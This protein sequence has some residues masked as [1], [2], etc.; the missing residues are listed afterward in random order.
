[1]DMAAMTAIRVKEKTISLEQ[2]L[3]LARIGDSM[4]VVAEA[5]EALV[6]RCWAEELGVEAGVEELQADLTQFR[7]TNGL[8]TAAQTKEW[9]DSRGVTVEELTDFLEPSILYRKLA[10][11]IVTKE[12]I[13]RYFLENALRYDQAVISRIVMPEYGQVQELRFRLEEGADFHRLARQYSH[14]EETRRAGGYAGAI[15]RH[16][17]GPEQSA[18]VFSAG[19]GEIVGPF[20]TR[21]GFELILVEELY[22]AELT[23]TLAAELRELL[24]RERLEAYADALDISK[25]IW[26]P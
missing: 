16:D 1:M 5:E 22:P 20:E 14:D 21:E 2:L 13:E 25:D 9:L 17:V 15:G 11:S 4:P 3:R 24:F 7:K 26:E 18:A 8:Y 6:L 19:E 12:E 10:E 23:D